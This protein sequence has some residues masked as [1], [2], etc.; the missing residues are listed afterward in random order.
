MG[1]RNVE[2]IQALTELEMILHRPDMFIGSC[3][4]NE[5]KE[6]CLD[7]NTR[8]AQKFIVSTPKG[9]VHLFREII[10]NAADNVQES[11]QKNVDPGYIKVNV[12][13]DKISVLN[14][15]L[16]IPVRIHPELH[17]WAPYVI[18]GML[19]TSTN[20]N[21]SKE[22][23]VGGRNGHGA[24]L[25]N[26]FSRTFKV[27]CGDPFTSQKYTQIWSNNMRTCSEPLIE[28]Y[29]G[30]GFTYV[31]FEPDVRGFSMPN[32]TEEAKALIAFITAEAC[33]V[34]KIPV[35][36]NEQE[37]KCQNIQDYVKMF[38]EE[39]KNIFSHIEYPLGTQF[40]E[41]GA[42]VNP[43]T[44]PSLELTIV[45][46]PRQGIIQAFVNG[47]EVPEGVHISVIMDTVFG[48]LVK[49]I[50]GG[51]ESKLIRISDVL[52][53]VSIFLE[54]RLNQPKFESQN[55]SKL[56]SPKPVIKV[57]EN[58]LKQLKNWEFVKVIYDILQSK[59]I[60][61]MD[62][63]MKKTKRNTIKKLVDANCI[64]N[65]RQ[66]EAL[67]I[68]EGD[69]GCGYIVKL[70][71][72][73]PN[74]VEYHGYWPC[75]GK[76]PNFRGCDIITFMNSDF[77]DMLKKILN[78]RENVDYSVHS[79]Y[80]TL[81]YKCIVL[82]M[83]PDVD[84]RHIIGLWINLFEDRYPSLLRIGYLKHYRTAL[85]KQEYRGSILSFDFMYDY[86][87]FLNSL[88]EKEKQKL[89]EPRYFKGLASCKDD[90]IKIDLQNLRISVLQFDDEAS[91]TLKF[92]FGSEHSDIRKDW[93]AQGD[94]KKSKHEPIQSITTFINTEA[95]TYA[96]ENVTRSIPQ[97]IDGFKDVQKKI[98]YCALK[99]FKS[100][101]KKPMKL[102][103]L[104]AY[105]TTNTIYRHGETSMIEAVIRMAQ[106]YI[107]ANN[108]SL[109]LEEGQFGSRERGGTD[110][111]QP[112]YIYTKL[113]PSVKKLFNEIDM[114][115]PEYEEEE[116]K[117]E[118]EFLLPI[119]CP[120]LFNGTKGIATG[121]STEF[122]AFDP[123]DVILWYKIF[124][125]GGEPPM[126]LP[127][128]R[129]FTGQ[130]LYRQKKSKK[131]YMKFEYIIQGRFE[132]QTIGG[133]PVIL[134][135]ELPIKTSQKD[136]ETFL[137]DLQDKEM[138]TKFDN[139]STHDKPYFIIYGFKSEIN[140]KTL[141]LQSK[142]SATNL[143]AIGFE[144]LPIKFDNI[145]HFMYS[146]GQTRLF[147]YQKRK[148]YIIEEKKKKIEELTKMYLFVFD[149]ATDVIKTHRRRKLDIIKDMNERGHDPKLLKE[150]D[151]GSTSEEDLEELKSKIDKLKQELEIIENTKVEQMMYEDICEF[152][153][154]YCK[155]YNCNP[156]Q[157]IELINR[158]KEY[159]TEPTEKQ[160]QKILEARAKIVRIQCQA[161]Q[162]E[163]DKIDAVK[164][165]ETKRLEEMKKLQEIAD[166]RSLGPP[167][168]IHLKFY[169]KIR[170]IEIQIP[171]TQKNEIERIKKLNQLDEK[172]REKPRKLFLKLIGGK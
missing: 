155:E 15:G 73:I 46:S 69:S 166:T 167:K 168:L 117:R 148:D 156:K 37:L 33:L 126:L 133:A 60:S 45:D 164:Q 8:K 91:E 135:S 146:F 10:S 107:G 144:G 119:I 131:N 54:C 18:F 65:G 116:D 108:Y 157:P 106:S 145:Q 122:P 59:A 34:T 26:I 6:F 100:D 36:F 41:K 172:E 163:Q 109:F 20:Y 162:K 160:K 154:E 47:I 120:L 85:I 134:I 110:A 89:K 9:F 35:F 51:E 82:F 96:L 14:T 139:Y 136:Y 113:R 127:F 71:S 137:N 29:T 153:K 53:H 31:E 150:C 13:D 140:I 48:N 141:K 99:H 24:K 128:Y 38:F 72:W 4:R 132:V 7:I 147:Y 27:V 86:F 149:V 39:T 68:P 158:I 22:R 171:Q 21:D 104:V 105:V 49:A 52:D 19:R 129:G 57:D 170:E 58:K 44:Q 101:N 40:N 125:T 32:I 102:P 17:L 28:E 83:D 77:I 74:G 62:K 151:L 169:K 81:K 130:I 98:V 115:L 1:S 3:D 159:V 2:D 25:T 30:P 70:R 67:F 94:P 88:E 92:S 16:N 165:V 79:N 138:I 66:G 121:W 55:K 114:K 112:R 80:I 42:L 76:I 123:L 11:R 64:K 124:L 90:D 142:I 111:G 5:R 43:N 84:G 93:I 95:I 161:K 61:K 78:L 50:N 23:L 75:Q 118:P 63:D 56:S 103:E 143:H 97:L 87:T 152:E 12:T